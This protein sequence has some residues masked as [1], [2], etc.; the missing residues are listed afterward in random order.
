M[1]S[2]LIFSSY[3]GGLYSAS[4]CCMFLYYADL[5]RRRVGVGY[6]GL[7]LAPILGKQARV[8]GER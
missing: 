5:R 2:L 8:L 4:V 1:S 7:D 3:P 6:I